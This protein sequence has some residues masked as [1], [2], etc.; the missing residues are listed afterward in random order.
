MGR[1]VEG[2]SRK[3][4]KEKK[5]KKEKGNSNKWQYLEKLVWT[6][7]A[8]RHHACSTNTGNVRK[9]GKLENWKISD[10]VTYSDIRKNSHM[11]FALCKLPQGICLAGLQ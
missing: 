9:P 2:R 4:G 5:A 3:K 8:R 1:G 11:G 7:A 10:A 6:N